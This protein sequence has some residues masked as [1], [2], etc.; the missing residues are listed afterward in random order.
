MSLTSRIRFIFA[1]SVFFLARMLH[2]FG[3]VAIGSRLEKWTGIDN[4]Q[5]E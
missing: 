1:L 3:G 2:I 4:N 5:N